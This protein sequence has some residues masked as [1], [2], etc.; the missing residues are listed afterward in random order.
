MLQIPKKRI[1]FY[2]HSPKIIKAYNLKLQM[3][4]NYNNSTFGFPWNGAGNFLQNAAASQAQMQQQPQPPALH[5]QQIAPLGTVTAPPGTQLTAIPAAAQ[6]P[7]IPGLTTATPPTVFNGTV[8]VV[9]TTPGFN[10]IP[11]VYNNVVFPGSTFRTGLQYPFGAPYLNQ[12]ENATSPFVGNWNYTYQNGIQHQQQNSV[13]PPLATTTITSANVPSVTKTETTLKKEEEETKSK[14]DD[15]KSQIA[16]QVS[17]LLSDPK[18]IQSAMSRLK[19]NSTFDS[20]I[21]SNTS[22]DT[23][24]ADARD[25][26]LS[27]VG[28][29]LADIVGNKLNIDTP[30]VSHDDALTSEYLEKHDPALKTVR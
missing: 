13:P 19:P 14:C 4:F 17:S 24:C 23:D 5:T 22:V 12:S 9:T 15:L 8:P 1:S 6:A 28:D 10:T 3:D 25:V 2:D 26:S 16:L 21:V 29:G 20:D 7:Q 30:D 18:V 27:G 11:P